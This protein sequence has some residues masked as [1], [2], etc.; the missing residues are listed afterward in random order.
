MET[1]VEALNIPRENTDE[2]G[3]WIFESRAFAP[4]KR[5]GFSYGPS[6]SFA[7]EP[8]HFWNFGVTGGLAASH[9]AHFV[10][11]DAIDRLR[12]SASTNPCRTTRP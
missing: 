9:I 6:A 8:W 2:G 5:M 4:I 7:G 10:I 11:R 12:F 3:A 1:A